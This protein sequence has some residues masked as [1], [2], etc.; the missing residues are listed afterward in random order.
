MPGEADGRNFVIGFGEERFISADIEDENRSAQLLGWVRLAL[1]GLLILSLV[2]ALAGWFLDWRAREEAPVRTA[3]SVRERVPVAAGAGAAAVA[4]RSPGASA[5]PNAG[6]VSAAQKR[7]NRS[8]QLIVL[9]GQSVVFGNDDVGSR[10]ID[11]VR[12]RGCLL[13]DDEILDNHARATVG[14][15][16]IHI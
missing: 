8:L 14:L 10:L 11:F 2:I 4:T 3:A 1:L 9:D 15:S 13:S 6:A 5:N 7:R 12:T 16:L